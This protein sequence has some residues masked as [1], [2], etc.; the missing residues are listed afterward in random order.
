MATDAL[1]LTVLAQHSP[2][3][4]QRGLGKGMVA[5]TTSFVADDGHGGRC[6]VVVPVCVPHDQRPEH[7]CADRGGLVDSTGPCSV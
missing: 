7:R 1:K 5:F 4:V 2:W 6:N 3:F